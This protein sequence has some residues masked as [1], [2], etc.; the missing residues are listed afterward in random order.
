MST[1][2]PTDEQLKRA[3]A[4]LLPEKLVY[5]CEQLCHTVI[6]DG[7]KWV[8]VQ[9]KDTELLQ[10]VWDIEE[11]LDKREIEYGLWCI[12]LSDTCKQ[13][14][15]DPVHATWQQRTIALATIKNIEIV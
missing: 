7:N 15:S 14:N 1:P 2:Q 5:H 8:S 13:T 10:L 4:I 9:V 11:T 3:L 12:K 6:V